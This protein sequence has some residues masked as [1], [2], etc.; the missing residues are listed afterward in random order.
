[1]I[2]SGSEKQ[3]VAK[4][5]SSHS[6]VLLL[7][8]VKGKVVNYRPRADQIRDLQKVGSEYTIRANSNLDRYNSLTRALIL[9]IQL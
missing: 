8:Q 4:F 5:N 9:K 7:A 2:Q 6:L 3:G 1:M